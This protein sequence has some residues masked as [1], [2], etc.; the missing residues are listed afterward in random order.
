MG[1]KILLLLRS[2]SCHVTKNSGKNASSF[3]IFSTV[4][5]A[6]SFEGGETH[7]EEHSNFVLGLQLSKIAHLLDDNLHDQCSHHR[8]TSLNNTGL[9]VLKHA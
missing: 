7:Q 3:F 9:D 4:R 8:A 6:F 2:A 1:E 5:T